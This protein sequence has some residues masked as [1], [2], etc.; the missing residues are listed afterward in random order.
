VQLEDRAVPTIT[1]TSGIN[2]LAN[3]GWNP[4]DTNLA[5]GPN[6]VLEVVNESLAIYDKATGAFRSQESLPTLFSGFDS[7]AI[8]Y[9]DP[10]V[11]YDEQAGRFVIEAAV[12]DS[13]NS[14]AFVDFAVSNS[15]DPTQGFTE[16]QQIEVDQGGQC[17]NDNG[18][19]GW[20]TDAY[21]YTGNLYTFA[22]NYSQE[23]V[24]TVQK[25]SVLDQNRATLTDYVVD[26]PGYFALIPA[27]MHGSVTGGPMWFASSS[28]SGGSSID[29]VRMDNLLSA[30]PTFTDTSVAVNS[31][32]NPPAATQ[33]SSTVDASDSRT[34]SVEW[35][36]GHLGVAFDAAAGS[37]AVAAWYE[38]NTGGSQ[39]VVSQQ[40]VIH[41]ASGVSTYFPAIAVDAAGDL[42]LTYM[43]SS[44]SEYVSVYVTGRLASDAASTLET[45]VRA[46]AGAGA[47]SNRAGDYSGIGLDPSA[48]NVF[49]AGNEYAPGGSGWGTWLAQFQVAPA[50]STD[51]PP[52]VATPASASP[53]P[54]TGTTTNL[55]VLGA[56]DTG[57]STLTYTWSDTS[58]P[59]GASAPT[60]SS[61][62]T[63]ASKNMTATFS[64]AGSYTFQVVI[65]DPAGLTVTSSVTVAV[66]Q[67]LTRI[68]VSPTPASVTEGGTQQFAASALD[69]FGQAMATQPSFSWSLGISSIGTVS[70]TGL[71]TAPIASTG[72]ATI[73]ATSSAMSGSATVTVTL[74][75][76]TIPAAPTNLTATAVS[77][78][79]VNLAW[80][81][82][83]TNMTGFTIQRRFPRSEIR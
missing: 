24:V 63:N 52:T 81:D 17:W 19:L 61:N 79:L 35:N 2:G 11:I 58:E 53:N 34:L 21:V 8:G 1:L 36:S 60:Y 66:N 41:P 30:T 75:G 72:S 33:P 64:R 3:T 69:Q 78:H 44:S 40:G 50:S 74:P 32:S 4:P 42:G 9:F 18:K 5:V 71:Y 31:Y 48:T 15:S 25:S 49:W 51:K 56:D 22:G 47:L 13:T 65:T 38:F 37:D 62:G 12:K 45:A 26:Q 20:N 73:N 77:A 16:I 80:A 55:S 27:R 46:K 43:E 29:V 23:V 67:T 54:V 76:P 68:S 39:P 70:S 28:W 10:S 14:K 57:E 6:Q 7:G 83:A 59:A 82:P